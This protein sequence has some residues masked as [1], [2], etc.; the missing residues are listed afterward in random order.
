MRPHQIQS[1]VATLF[2]ALLATGCAER[3][4]PT[5][6]VIDVSS[7]GSVAAAKPVPPPPANAVYIANLTPSPKFI[8]LGIEG[9]P[10]TIT[11]G[12]TTGAPQGEIYVQAELTQNGATYGAGGT[13]SQC[14][15]QPLGTIP[16]GGCTF[17]WAAYANQPG[18]QRGGASLR[19]Y[20]FDYDPSAGTNTELDSRTYSVR[21]R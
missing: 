3:A 2:V 8:P 15:G 14:Q 20:I 13:I 9:A 7:P 6:P 19:I 17:D 16:A 1:S 21:L 10:Y 18:L 11:I 4:A 12:N 5:E